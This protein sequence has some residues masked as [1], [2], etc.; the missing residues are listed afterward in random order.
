MI[1]LLNHLS[2]KRAALEMSI[3]TIVIVVISVTML[4]MGLILVRTIMCG[5]LVTSVDLTQKMKVQINKLFQDTGNDVAMLKGPQ[6]TIKIQPGDSS[7][8]WFAFRPTVQTDYNY[9][10]EVF[11]ADKYK[12]APYS[13]RQSDIQGWFTT[14][15]SGREVVGTLGKEK[16]LILKPPKETPEFEFVL[17]LKVNNVDREEVQVAIQKQGWVYTAFC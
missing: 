13:L 10:F 2:R 12:K 9:R 3:S 7:S 11:L 14:P 4:I 16:N 6:N 17:R 1:P 15:L 5:A 8:I